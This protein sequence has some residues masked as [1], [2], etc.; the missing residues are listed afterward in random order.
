MKRFML[1]ALALFSTPLAASADLWVVD[2]GGG[3]NFTTIQEAITAAATGDEIVVNPGQ[4][5]EN[6]DFLGKNLWLHSAAGPAGTV[7]DGSQGPYG[8]R[9]CVT[10]QYGES[11]AAILEGFT[12]TGGQGTPDY[13]RGGG[14]RCVGSSPTLRACWIVG[15]TA[16]HGAGLYLDAASP[17]VEACEF[18]NN[19]AARY[20]GAINGSGSP[21]INDC[22]FESN[23]SGE[24]GGA[25]ASGT[26]QGVISDCR[27]VNN[28][29]TLDGGAMEWAYG[30]NPHILNCVFLG[31]RAMT[32]HG[33]AIRTYIP[34]PL[35][36]GCLFA[37][38]WAA[39]DGG[40]VMTH[41]GGGANIQNCT[42]FANGAG[43]YGGNVAIY[44]GGQVS[45]SIIAG[46]T[47]GGGLF[48]SGG[49]LYLGCL[50]AWS[51][52][53]G[54][55]LGIADPTGTNGNIAENPIFCDAA[56][57]DFTIR[58]D[59]PCAP[60]QNPTCGLIGAYDVGCSV[61][62]PTVSATWGK[63]KSLYTR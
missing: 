50:D 27:F 3:G 25:I 24:R 55:Y 21:T 9:T 10:F 17:L 41:G 39:E 7:I 29:A 61:P 1:I 37:D 5:V 12:I 14:I 56:A 44:D 58:E 20:G 28:V 32:V 47:E 30:A 38:N 59:S 2:P 45:N 26:M 49:G 43:R 34:S 35:I 36:E 51:N 46:A 62:A 11:L 8:N 16:D 42:F 18:R 52:V 6:L 53:G 15:N 13:L 31:N 33:G 60:Q 23:S 4:Y 48:C 54:N 22:L 40:G 63:I 19:V 57:H